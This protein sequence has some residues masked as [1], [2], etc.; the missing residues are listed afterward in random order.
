MPQGEAGAAKS[1]DGT[2]L[3]NL[4]MAYATSG[5]YDKGISLIEQGI[6]KG[7]LA[8]L[9]EAKLH[10]G[11]VYFWAGQK[12]Q[13]IKQLQTVQGADGIG[14]LARYWVMEINHPLLSK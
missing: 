11:L 1:K 12:D 9:E 6:T 10:L 4:G 8:R 14:D 3:V 7:G 5:Q 13:A 2:G